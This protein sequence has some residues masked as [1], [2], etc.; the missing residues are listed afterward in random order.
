MPQPVVDEI[1]SHIDLETEIGGYEASDSQNQEINAFYN[2]VA[3][4]FGGE[5]YNYAF[6]TNATDAF[7]RALSSIPF[8][9]GDII[10]TSDNDYISNQIA[11]ISLK[12]RFGIEIHRM[13]NTSDG[14]VDVQET[15]KLCKDISP[16]LV[17]ITHV[18][19]NSGIIQPVIELGEVCRKN[20]LLFLVDACQSMGQLN[21]NVNKLNCDFLSGT[22]R[23]FMRGPR[24]A[25]ILYVSD[26]VL[27]GG[28]EPLFID[29]R[30]AKWTKSDEYVIEP[31]AKRFEDWE[32]AYALLLGSKAA[33][34]YANGIG[35]DNIEKRVRY[36]SD[37]LRD[38]LRDKSNLRILDEGANLCGVVTLEVKKCTLDQLQKVLLESS[39][40][41]SISTYDNAVIHFGEKKVEW[42]L[43]V[44]PHYYNTIDEINELF[45]VLDQL[46]SS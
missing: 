12:K 44:S 7:N 11:F 8:K 46:Q 35:I 2:S 29:M 21:V 14:I 3:T 16:K 39:I 27:D 26:R 22:F 1:K 37:Y 38:G 13:P 36:L 6:C 10:L 25:G 30:G 17:A 18:P 34:E 4:F 32:F 31:T 33:I 23:K 45:L 24:G 43:R 15:E 5:P 28:L 41:H 19:T 42:A 40:N 9:N 20:E